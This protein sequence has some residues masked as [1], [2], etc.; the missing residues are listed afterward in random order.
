MSLPSN[1]NFDYATVL[2]SATRDMKNSLTLMLQ[3]IDDIMQHSQA[4]QQSA[5]EQLADINY[6]VHRLNGVLTQLV[7][8]YNREQG[9][10][11]V[12]LQEV[13]VADMLETLFYQNELH[14]LTQGVTVE[15]MVD[16]DLQWYLD[17]ELLTCMIDE[18]LNS[19]IR[20]SRDRVVIS[21]QV[22]EDELNITINDDSDGYPARMMEAATA[23][24]KAL[25]TQYG[26]IG[27]GLLFAR[28][29]T[30]AHRKG[31][32]QGRVELSNQGELGGSCF[33]IVLP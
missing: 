4:D 31:D 16:Q 28:L 14:S 8:L 15:L 9:S 21:A 1:D 5:N 18:V 12:N 29:V 23:P 22:V 6:Q 10:L 17:Q 7:G 25:E 33:S 19:A 11:C 27:I 2:S 3:S 13:L 24:I 30:S 20:Y 26:K 32:R